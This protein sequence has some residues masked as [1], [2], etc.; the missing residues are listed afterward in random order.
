MWINH[1]FFKYAFGALLTLAVI[2]LFGKIDYINTALQGFIATIFFP[3]AIA[4]IFY[5][6]FR[7]LVRWLSKHMP[8]MVAILI[9]FTT[10]AGIAAGAV[11]FAGS[12]VS[13]QVQQL[14]Q[15][16]PEKV[17]EITNQ[18]KEVIQENNFGL[19]SPQE[20]EEKLLSYSRSITED[21]GENIY[22]I[23]STITSVATV[24]VVVPFLLFFLLRDEDKIRPQ[25]LKFIPPEHEG[26]GNK[27]LRDIDNTLFTYVTGQA[28]VAVAVGV[29]MYIGYLIIGL[30]YGLVLALF[31]MVLTIVPLLGPIIGII[32]AIFVGLLDSPFMVLK[33]I[34]VM[35]VVQQLEGN[36]VEPVVFGK[37]LHIHPATVILL[38]LVAGSLYGFIGILI[39][40]P[41][42]SVLKVVI[43][44][45]WKFYKLR[46]QKST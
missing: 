40:V 14:T 16:F 26:E 7:P 46:H 20:V 32:P 27:I 23:F 25:I 35:I 37:R 19:V 33:V 24:L 21:L 28:L 31:A 43:K 1:P 12:Q 39:A 38:L 17:D 34:L 9:V 42:Y 29:L 8:R 3:L 6:L 45:T 44:D 36:L 5:Y 41:L 13:E 10:V 4:G 30:N 22:S 11:Y 2:Y 18:S 15:Q